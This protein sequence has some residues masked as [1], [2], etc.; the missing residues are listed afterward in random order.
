MD[1][2]T[3]EMLTVYRAAKTYGGSFMQALAD[4]MLR[5]DRNNLLKIKS[6]WPHEWHQYLSLGH[7]LEAEDEK[8][9][10]NSLPF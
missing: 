5:A 8:L 1:D 7:Q 10:Q 3:N 9:A 6:T 4:A 2:L